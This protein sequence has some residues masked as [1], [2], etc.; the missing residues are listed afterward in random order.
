MIKVSRRLVEAVKL[1]DRPAYALAWQAG[2]HPSVLSKLLHG[3]ER[4]QECDPRVLRV[5][6]LLGVRADDAFEVESD[7]V[8]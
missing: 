4:V 1:S 7:G 3:A 8:R 6:A 2:I 5:A